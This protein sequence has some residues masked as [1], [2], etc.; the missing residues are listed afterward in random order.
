MWNKIASSVALRLP[1]N[2][3]N[4]E[5]C[6]CECFLLCVIA[7]VFCEAIFYAYKKTMNLPNK[8]TISRILLV[9]VFM[10]FLFSK[11]LA[12]KSLALVVFLIAAMTDYLDGFIA[13]KYNI[14]SD[15]GKIMDPVA[16]KV[17]TLAAFLVFVEMKLVPAWMV[18]IIIMRELVITSIRI[19]ALKN[20][21]VL[22]AGRGG[23]HKTV[24]QMFSIFVIL[25]F[26]IIKESGIVMFGF[27]NAS[28]EYWYKQLIFLLMTITV[29]LT[30]ISGASYLLG[31]KK[32]LGGKSP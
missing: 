19:M 23:K 15:F 21:E 25:V 4:V 28:F 26:I 10:V 24:S 27:W 13:K 12:A 18:V 14:V 2:D 32:Y 5:S 8:I 30:T 6:H 11:G 9:F 20:N 31:N 17:L 22:P 1:R 16:D 29:I 7:S 3:T